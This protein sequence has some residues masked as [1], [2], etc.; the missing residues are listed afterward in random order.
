MDGVSMH[1]HRTAR[2]A[3]ARLRVKVVGKRELAARDA[4]MHLMRSHVER[5]GMQIVNRRNV[6]RGKERPIL[7]PDELRLTATSLWSRLV[8]TES[9]TLIV[10][11]LREHRG[12][13]C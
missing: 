4:H 13:S 2:K 5:Y 12:I 6:G 9:V 3:D 7:E 1:S 10:I 11:A 8:Q